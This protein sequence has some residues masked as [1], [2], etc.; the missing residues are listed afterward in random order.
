MAGEVNEVKLLV[1]ASLQDMEK[2]LANVGKVASKHLRKAGGDLGGIGSGITKDFIAP[3]QN[4]SLA[5]NQAGFSATKLTNNLGSIARYAKSTGGGAAAIGTLTGALVDLKSG[6][7]TTDVVMQR[8]AKNGVKG[9]DMLAESLGT[10]VPT[11]MEMVRQRA[12]SSTAVIDGLTAGLDRASKQGTRVEQLK[13]RF[14]GLSDS[15]GRVG[16]SLTRGLTLPLAAAGAGLFAAASRAGSYAEEILN[17][18]AT[19]GMS[20]TRLQGL[21]F[22]AESSG[23]NF[24]T[25]SNGI[26]QVQKKLMGVEEDSGAA[27]DAFKR[28][29]IG[30]YDG[31]GALLSMDVLFPQLLAKLQALPNATERNMLAAQIFG[32]GWTEL[33]PILNMSGQQLQMLTDQATSLGLVMSTTA[34]EGA[35]AFDDKMDALMGR[36]QGFGLQLGTAAIPALTA[37]LPLITEQV[38]PAITGLVNGVASVAQWFSGLPAPAQGAIVAFAGLLMAIGPLL[39]IAGTLAGAISAIIGLAPAMATAGAT[40]GAGFTAM[41]GPIGLVIAG[42]VAIGALIAWMVKRFSKAKKDAAAKD[43]QPPAEITK[44]IPGA[45][46]N[47]V[48]FAKPEKAKKA[49]AAKLTAQEQLAAELAANKRIMAATGDQKGFAGDQAAAYRKALD[50]MAREGA[51]D[52]DMAA[53]GAKLKEAEQA[54]AAFGKKA[55]PITLADKFGNRFSELAG[56][57]P[58]LASMPSGVTPSLP[59]VP[60]MATASPAVSAAAGAPLEIVLRLADQLLDARIGAVADKRVRVRIERETQGALVGA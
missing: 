14:T 58:M 25:L 44:D 60:A 15:L 50:R 19:T 3:L 8:L 35:A 7:A 56:A 30:I 1:T 39:S 46:S 37:L 47:T 53:M 49:K 36:L 2:A 20:T 57:A 38:L 24:S 18:S 55:K 52:A 21:K 40:M 26:A 11:A 32:K 13:T 10:D 33:A 34:L 31:N 17:L 29:G 45:S 4:A 9:W 41:L 12:I 22:A 43:L 48:D 42:I 27:A 23:L 6:S 54:K 51:S 5:M 16:G 59:S 28:L